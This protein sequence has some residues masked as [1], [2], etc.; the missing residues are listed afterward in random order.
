MKNI[1][2]EDIIA[3]AKE[4]RNDYQ[5]KWRKKYKEQHGISYQSAYLL[6]RAERELQKAKSK[7]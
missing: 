7:R 3:R 5:R 1:T 2:Q 4:I 6:K